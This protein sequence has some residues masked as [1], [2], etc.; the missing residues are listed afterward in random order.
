MKDYSWKNCVGQYVLAIQRAITGGEATGFQGRARGQ[1]QEGERWE[2]KS[3][4]ESGE[5]IIVY[6]PVQ[7][8]Q[9]QYGKFLTSI[10]ASGGSKEARGKGER[11]GSKAEELF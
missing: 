6:V 10:N 7:H 3:I 1:G 8:E 4:Q 11:G 9:I 5:E 2:E